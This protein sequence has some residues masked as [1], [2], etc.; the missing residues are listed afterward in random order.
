[1]ANPEDRKSKSGASLTD[2]DTSTA[3][4][5]NENASQPPGPVK[6]LSSKAPKSD[7]ANEAGQ[8]PSGGYQSPAA[9]DRAQTLH[10]G[11]TRQAAIQGSVST[12]DRQNQGK[13]DSR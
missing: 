5:G 3:S 9:A 12:Q 4:P 7:M 10:E 8:P 2:P 13:R 6:D 1:M 11:E